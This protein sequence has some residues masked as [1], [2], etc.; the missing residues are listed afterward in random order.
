MHGRSDDLYTA[1]IKGLL[2]RRGVHDEGRTSGNG[3]VGKV[4]SLNFGHHDRSGDPFL[5]E[6]EREIPIAESD[7]PGGAGKQCKSQVLTRDIDGRTVLLKYQPVGGQ[8]VT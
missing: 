1:D 2:D 3:D 8:A 7:D 4:R 6:P 5:A